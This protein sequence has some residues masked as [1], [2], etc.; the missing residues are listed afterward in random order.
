MSSA[1]LR[2]RDYQLDPAGFELCRAGHRL[3]L[4][5]KP[6]ELLILLAENQG[7]LVKREEIIEKIWGKDFFFDAENG[8]N[9][10]IR[11]IR[12]ALNDNA[13]HPLFV[14]TSLGKGYRF[15]APVERIPNPTGSAVPERVATPQEPTRF[16]WRRAWF[17]ALGVTALIA[18]AFALN[19]AGIRSRIFARGAP[20]I[21]SIVVLPLENLSGDPTQEYF[22]DG[23][24]DAVITQLAQNTNLKVISRT[25][26]MQ[27][28]AARKPLPEIA[29]ELDVD[30]VVEGTVS[31]SGNRVRI[32][33][34]LL[35]ARTDRHLWAQSYERELTDIFG[36]QDDVAR[37][38]A[39]EIRVT[40]TPQNQAL[41][42]PP[43]LAD[44]EA[45]ENYLKGRYYWNKA[46]DQG[47]RTG[48]GFFEKAVEK[49]P[50]Y[51][52]A[53]VGLAFAYNML[54]DYSRA[55]E[56][57]TRALA[58]DGGSGEAHAAFAVITW[59][60]DWDWTTAGHE[61]KRA[62][63]LDPNNA[64][65]HHTYGLYLS[66]LGRQDEARAQLQRTLEL[67]PLAPFA[68]ANLGSIYWSNHDFD[69]AIQQLKTALEVDPSLA[70]THFY[71][72]LV[73]E[74]LARYNEALV[75]FEKYRALSGIPFESKG[76]VVHLYAVQG[77]HD[78]LARAEFIGAIAH[79]YAVQ[80]RRAEAMKLLEL[81]KAAHKPGD[82]LSYAIA[83]GYVGL[84]DKDHAFPWLQNS[85]DEHIDDMVDLNDDVRMDPLRSDPRF[86]DL[87]RRVGLPV[88]TGTVI[89]PH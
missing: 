19:V 23:M 51:A 59:F 44:P 72:G 32:T 45:Y 76:P 63:E 58:L 71:L 12:S 79:L 37:D 85:C 43:H 66:A 16:P 10:A 14:E 8:V 28:K 11:K 15:I 68:Y 26:S 9:N 3:R 18:A 77:R 69:R 30:A 81:L 21:H 60:K 35:A 73:Y 1:K 88:N 52:Q 27:Y 82:M 36:L 67:D 22:V 38:I 4:E 84:G 39:Q 56:A 65:A 5:R 29:R 40:V 2:F 75:E 41:L 48:Q 89:A 49:D 6:M 47:V 50:S 42:N 20:A 24:T 57:A 55:K 34:Q 31:R 53:W 25:S 62:I 87:V 74:S 78:I 54:D 7:H 70:D 33:A 17:P 83:L 46:T 13:E 80:G 61:F 64:N 86:Q